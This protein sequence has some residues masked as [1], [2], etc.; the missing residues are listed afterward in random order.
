MLVVFLDNQ[1]NFLHGENLMKFLL[2]FIFIISPCYAFNWNKCKT[3]MRKY[4]QGPINGSALI[5]STQFTTSWGDCAMIGMASHD[6][7]VFLAHNIEELKTDSARGGGEYLSAYATL[8]RCTPSSASE[9][10]K[11]IQL[12]FSLIYGKDI[13]KTPEA[14]YEAMERMIQTDPV[15][16]L[17]CVHKS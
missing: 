3:G 9:L 14:V 11:S 12:N 13:S 4:A 16:A 8:S 1:I 15:L 17:G 5:S 6:K 10:S 7:K 2:I